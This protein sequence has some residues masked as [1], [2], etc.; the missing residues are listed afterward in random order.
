MPISFQLSQFPDLG[1][2]PGEHAPLVQLPPLLAA[3]HS[4]EGT[5]PP[6]EEEARSFRIRNL[7]DPVW[8]RVVPAGSGLQAGDNAESE[9]LEAGDIYDFMLTANQ[10]ASLW[11]LDIRAR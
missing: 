3:R 11:Q 7:G 9:W 5:I 1:R 8:M 6:F 2:L 10:L 4:A